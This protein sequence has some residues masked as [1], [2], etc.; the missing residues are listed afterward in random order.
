[1]VAGSDQRAVLAQHHAQP[2]ELGQGV[3]LP[4]QVVQADCGPAG[5][6]RAG[7]RADLEQTEIMVVRR[8]G[9]LQEGRP[10]EPLGGHLHPTEAEHVDV[11]LD[12]TGHIADEQHRV[13][14]A[15]DRHGRLPFVR[16]RYGWSAPIYVAAAVPIRARS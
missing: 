5:R 1:V 9:R 16:L 8:V 7:G 10:A 2:V 3:H 11:E 13:V 14:E 15:G 4:G 6:G 12:A